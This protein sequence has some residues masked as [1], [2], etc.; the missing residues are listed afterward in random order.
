MATISKTTVAALEARGKPYDFRDGELKGFLVRVH[1][2]SRKVYY[3]ELGRGRRMVIGPAD[4]ITPAQARDEAKR[5][6]AEATL[7]VDPI[8]DRRK[9]NALT[10]RRFLKD[11]YEP[12]VK[13]HHKDAKETLRRLRQFAGSFLDKK[14]DELC[15]WDVEKERSSRLKAGV[16]RTTINREV[17]ALRSALSKAVEWPQKTGL[18][19]HPFATVKPLKIDRKPRVRYLDADEEERLRAALDAREGRLRVGRDSANRWR[20]ERGYPELPELSTRRFADRLKPIV[21]IAI[22]TG[23]RRGEIFSLKWSDVDFERRIVT[24]EGGGAKSLQT[25]HVPMNR[26]AFGTLCGW[27]SDQRGEGL[28]FPSDT[29][30]RLDNIK[31][32]WEA[33]LERAKIESF[34]FHDLRHHF[35]SRLAMAGVNLNVIRELLGH[36]DVKMVLRYAHLSA[37]TKAEAVERISHS[38]AQGEREV[39]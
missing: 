37:D 15:A 10:L 28:V 34:R 22:N 36:S 14:L 16:E 1:P 4:R 3:V 13:E 27:Q 24:V 11:L 8:E 5:K 26:E 17:G 19:I 7:G 21:L 39:L 25:R 32:S 29:G 6:L 31:K 18:K 30:G 20:R 38:P 12:W 9:A 2:T 23:L 33:V 35:A